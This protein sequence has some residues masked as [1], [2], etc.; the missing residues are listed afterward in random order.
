MKGMNKM[1]GAKCAGGRDRASGMRRHG[2]EGQPA[3][4]SAAFLLVVLLGVFG[5]CGFASAWA[6]QTGPANGVKG[7]FSLTGDWSG[8][9]KF[10]AASLKIVFH[11]TAAGTEYSA[12]MDS[13]DQGARGIPISAVRLDG[14]NVTFEVAAVGGHY[15]GTLNESGESIEGT[16]KQSGLSLPLDLTRQ[17]AQ[18]SQVPA[19]TPQEP[20]HEARG[21]DEPS[22]PFPYIAK[23]VEF[24][25][26]KICIRL[27]GSLTIPEGKGPFPAVVLVSGSGPQNRD[28]EILGHKP[29]LVLAD[30]LARCGIAT[31]RYDDRGVGGSTGNFQTATTFD[32]VDD[33][34]VALDFLAEQPEVDARRVGVIGHSEGATVAS[35][36]AAR[37]AKDEQN[38][39]ENSKA[40]A[41]VAFI[42]LL[43]GPGVQGDELLLLQNA[44]LGRA[45]GLSDEQISE[46]N[47]LNRE[48]YS[49]AMSSEED[50]AMLRTKLVETLADALNSTS[51]LTEQQKHARRVQ[52]QAQADQ[53]LSPWMRTFLALDP[54]DYLRKVGVPV[55]AL[56]G[57]KDLQVPARENLA[58]IAAALEAAGNTTATLI[59]LEG[60]NHLFQHAVTGLPSEYGE[61]RETFA[62]EA[63]QHIGDW[64]LNL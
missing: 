42:V 8:S 3:G 24:A 58:A 50:A 61:I 64:I 19:E 53:L 39:D 14:K 23:D 60:L 49:I 62:P 40:N 55:L 20:S 31:L 43:A 52:A 4:R 27:A 30:Y 15:R 13:P 57:S 59:E 16:W 10:G 5:V 2:G 29:F 7:S 34:Q 45:F 9:L 47:R 38:S 17:P 41:K 37:G 51:D 56:Y 54:S 36:L 25:D 21:G 44:A 26:E 33:A 1:Q 48:L 35:I 32:F 18:T 12:T 22:S 6:Q 11:V 28:E 46:A 63:L